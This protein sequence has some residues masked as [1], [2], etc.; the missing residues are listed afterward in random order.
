MS[1]MMM[2]RVALAIKAATDK[3]SSPVEFYVN[4]EAWERHQAAHPDDEQ[5]DHPE[6]DWQLESWKIIA[7]AAITAMREPTEAMEVAA[8]G[9]TRRIGQ[10]HVAPL[11]QAMIDEALKP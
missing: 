2:E 9:T 6:I 7:R 1:E 4:R 11:W 10:Y 5:E 8:T 3:F